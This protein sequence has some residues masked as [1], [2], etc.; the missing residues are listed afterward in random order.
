MSDV[1][2]Q[3]I[4]EMRFDNK[5]FEENV[6][7]SINTLDKLKE[8]LKFDKVEGNFDEF[9]KAS[10]KIDFSSLHN[11]LNSVGE[12]ISKVF[13]EIGIGALRN[14]GASLEGQ[15]TNA[16]RSMT[17]IDQFGEGWTKYGEKTQSV[18]TIMA[19]TG[20]SIDEVS[21][22]LDRLNW[23]SDET[24]Y[25]FTDM[26][27]N[28]GKF[29]SAGVEL[30]DAVEAMQGISTWAALSGQNS[31]TAA[32]AM[33]NLSQAMGL[34]YVGLADWKSIELANMGT[35][36][37]KE[38]LLD[39]AAAMGTLTKYSDGTYQAIKANGEA[40]DVTAENMRSTLDTKW[41]T[42]DVLMET[43]S[44]YGNFADE[45]SKISETTGIS[46]TD[47]M[48]A[49][50]SY[51]GSVQSISKICKESGI[52]ADELVPYL[53]KLSG[54]EYELGRKAFRA[55]QESKTLSDSLEATKDAVSTGWMKTF[56]LLFGNYEQA[57]EVFTGLS[58]SLYDIFAES[59]N[60]RNSIL[61]DWSELGGGDIFR[62]GLVNVMDGIANI[63]SK[64]RDM[65]YDA[66]GIFSYAVDENGNV[67]DE[68]YNFVQ[69]LFGITEKFGEWSEKFLEFTE[70]LDDMPFM[71]HLW[72][73]IGDIAGSIQD[74]FKIAWNAVTALKPVVIF[75]FDTLGQFLAPL[76]T[77]VLTFRNLIG[78]VGDVAAETGIFEGAIAS[79]IDIIS[80][81]VSI[82][83]KFI[84]VITDYIYDIVYAARETKIFSN[85]FAGIKILIDPVIQ[86]FKDFFSLFKNKLDLS[87][88]L[89][90]GKAFDLKPFED[91]SNKIIPFFE[92]LKEKIS[93]AFLPIT[94]FITEHA[95]RAKEILTIGLGG[96][97]TV[98]TGI[99]A[100]LSGVIQSIVVVAA[101]VVEK[102]KEFISLLKG[103]I[104]LSQFLSFDETLNNIRE[105]LSPIH[106]KFTAIFND[107][108]EFLSKTKFGEI[109]L[110]SF[111]KIQNILSPIIK[112]LKDFF[113]IFSTKIDTD[114]FT[115]FHTILSKIKEI[116]KP[117]SDLLSGIFTGIKEFDFSKTFETIS[118]FFR[119]I[120]D[121]IKDTLKNVNF[122]DIG[123]K[124]IDECKEIAKKIYETFT[125]IDFEHIKE[126]IVNIF[127][128]IKN[129]IVE[130]FS[131]LNIGQNLQNA[132]K[133]IGES[134]SN[135]S[136]SNI[137]G[138]LTQ[139]MTIFGGFN[140]GKLAGSLSDS[141][142]G[143]DGDIFDNISSRLTDLF[144]GLKDS[145]GSFTKGT[146]ENKLSS[147]AKNIGIF[148]GALLLLASIDQ[149][150]IGEVLVGVGAAFGGTFLASKGVSLLDDQAVKNIK[151]VGIGLVE[152]AGAI[153]IM[154][155]ALAPLA[156]M[157]GGQLG[158]M[159]GALTVLLTEILISVSIL[160]KKNEEHDAGNV[161][162]IGF[163]L[164]EIAA[165]IKIIIGALKD[166]SELNGVDYAQALVAL[167]AILGELSVIIYIAGNKLDDPAALTK[168]GTAAVLLGIAMNSFAS[169]F[170]KLG[171]QNFGDWLEALIAFSSIMAEVVVFTL[172]AG[173]VQ[174]TDALAKSGAAAVLLGKAMKSFAKAF[175]QLGK[176]NFGDWLEAL[177]AFSSIMAEVI[178]FTLVAGTLQ[179]TDG[180]VK[181]GAAAIL[182][183]VAMNSLAKAFNQLGK[184]NFGD[185]LQA[186]IAFSAIMAEMI[187]FNAFATLF[188][189]NSIMQA[190]AAMVVLAAAM[191]LLV[192]ALTAFAL[193]PWKSFEYFSALMGSM[194]VFGAIAGYLS[195]ISIGLLA[196]GTALFEIGAGVALIGTGIA[197]I[198]FGL[199]EIA[200]ALVLINIAGI[201]Q[202]IA[203][204]GMGLAGLINQLDITLLINNVKLFFGALPEIVSAFL[205][206]LI[207][208]FA[209]VITA[210]K[211]FVI[212]LI[213]AFADISP[214]I[215]DALLRILADSLVSLS[216]NLATI[217]PTIMDIVIQLLDALIE[218]LPPIIEKLAFIFCALF[219]GLSNYIPEMLTSLLTFFGK[220]FGTL[221][222]KIGNTPQD[223]INKIA[224]M[225]LGLMVG[226]E[227][228]N[229]IKSAIPGAM[230]GLAEVS[231]FIAELGVII[232]AFG[233]LN[234]IPG[235]QMLV[236]RGGDLLE[237]IG[238]AIGKMIGGVVGG[239][240]EGATSTM[241]K[242]GENIAGFW[243]N[244]EPFI[245]GVSDVSAET[246]AK[247]GFLSACIYAL[248]AADLIGGIADFFREKANVQE[249]G[250]SIADMW[251]NIKPFIDG[252]SQVSQGTV[253]AVESLT[254][255][256]LMLTAAQLID[257]IT[258]FVFGKNDIS[259]F[260][261]SLNELGPY[262]KNFSDS[263][264]GI[265]TE[266]V[267][268]SA[269]VINLLAETFDKDVFKSG[270]LKQLF[271]GET[272]DLRV[273]AAG[274]QALGPS[275]MAYSQ[276]VKGLDV[277]VVK[278]STNAANAMA[279]MAA[280]LP[281]SNG[282]VQML[283]G[284][285]DLVD[286]SVGLMM[287]GPNLKQYAES[288]KGLDVDVV[289]NSTLA[290]QAISEFSTNLDE[291]SL[292]DRIFGRD[293]LAEF[294]NGMTTLGTGLKEFNDNIKD[295][296]VSQITSVQGAVASIMEMFS[297]KGEKSF[298]ID[299]AVIENMKTAAADGI[300]AFAGAISDNMG[301]ISQKGAEIG[302]AIASGIFSKND[303][304]VNKIG[305][306]LSNAL[307]RVSNSRSDFKTNAASLMTNFINGM[308]SMK[309][310]S[311]KK[312]NEILDSTIAILKSKAQQFI[313]AGSSNITSFID[314]MEAVLK[315]VKSSSS[316]LI[317]TI[318]GLLENHENTSSFTNAGK[319]NISAFVN[320]MNS[321][322]ED[323]KTAAG[324][325][326]TAI[327]DILW[328]EEIRNK[329][330]SAG[331]NVISSYIDGIKDSFS[332]P[333]NEN[334]FVQ[335]GE[336]IASAFITGMANQASAVETAAQTL[337]Q[338]I[339]SKVAD[340]ISLLRTYIQ[341]EIDASL[342]FEP[343]IT[344]V[345]DMSKADAEFERWNEDHKVDK[346]ADDNQGNIDREQPERNA[347]NSDPANQETIPQTRQIFDRA[348]RRDV[349][350]PDD[351]V[352]T[353]A[354]TTTNSYNT[355]TYNVNVQSN[356]NSEKEMAEQ[357]NKALYRAGRSKSYALIG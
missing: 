260:G 143:G 353:F 188:D 235:F 119:N 334:S 231:L 29:T 239:I 335:I 61:K 245:K 125:N 219:D 275:I 303:T 197:L 147:V 356:G 192:P 47:F 296:S 1:I 31:T 133:N 19:A 185:W 4:L 272:S 320:G 171:K 347:Q 117:V 196:I 307:T 167:T 207:N 191:N 174:N 314:G 183:G 273:F 305:K 106:E 339:R 310:S 40:I 150:K 300:T 65:I 267:K 278:N 327:H 318:L 259:N 302:E 329:F 14:F 111:D 123:K 234:S 293:K 137:L 321:V 301:L 54:S 35:I 163:A 109:V 114:Q 10:E 20:R 176:Q 68:S 165:A 82:F 64:I 59:G 121:T 194:L 221:I 115:S 55:A 336:D 129:K 105:K 282:I 288:V 33:Y 319:E 331:G 42:K 343:V 12:T 355:T 66:T 124:L 178:V 8:S 184:P 313:D 26:T 325:I 357:I 80:P 337:G 316:D 154:V 153:W 81:I 218:Y 83:S 285:S 322:L 311:D 30:E 179:S 299:T 284:E 168:A 203:Q 258:S 264:K 45:L 312:A 38:I 2:D 94:T 324:N 274:L 43:L 297:G 189:S 164:I 338:T 88:K 217:I 277:D 298:K 208:S 62:N 229:L 11:K 92:S 199:V 140:L 330:S 210:A 232:A 265:D 52:S 209:G 162:K 173:K 253:E 243:T 172:V 255:A 333:E 233:A 205:V 342:H 120:S 216:E 156:N 141:L 25:S 349:Y 328:S 186:M 144:G 22:Q 201:L 351:E 224:E 16:L 126:N 350:K 102:I 226:I 223:T 148:A 211:D 228:L 287:L 53:E 166:I 24:S 200:S 46:A 23:F 160:T 149:D 352:G 225:F 241:P 294:V 271:S 286:F 51:D 75:L 17:F 158:K 262:L 151:G 198:G 60:I 57:K 238:T 202:S 157:D 263:V 289:K 116:L 90:F 246:V 247:V 193:L 170:N 187:V 181:A 18:Q 32:R 96:A 142:S 113:G 268:V 74:A 242:V 131:N 323:S 261:T 56:E 132:G 326:I 240:A 220:L 139:A 44:A 283:K 9:S 7:D 69:K 110:S 77:I 214:A 101:V 107:V 89:G 108:K 180:L 256:I 222:E 270:G 155:D 72:N 317:D 78:I 230:A 348:K 169:A 63:V 37:F 315:D 39:T 281:P 15:F 251:T 138:Y 354:S 36:E 257:G 279:E 345:V 254:K 190:S 100:T 5:Q 195:P 73:I 71:S 98:L 49:L 266:A 104:S 99:I 295:I 122:K 97:F 58:N 332:D 206:G 76:D 13:N 84:N 340:E 112:K 95:P 118:G 86:K 236:E 161:K 250:K 182:L 6:S 290:A 91:F 130:T 146:D 79:V 204:L 127:T 87:N 48:R 252:V 41:L 21:E 215:V 70:N 249:F 28:V 103:D 291:K 346:P 309:S 276:S 145:L 292:M 67:L 136:F 308:D 344:P 50:D 27:N 227:I 248:T 152:I 213:N 244:I 306:I 237:A 269:E 128:S 212:N 175:N 3:K 135:I 177:I 134:L 34:G 159:A 85:I 341:E 93:N 280:K 304:I